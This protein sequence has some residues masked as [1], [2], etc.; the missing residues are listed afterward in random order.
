MQPR[1]REDT[2]TSIWVWLKP[3]FD[4]LRAALSIVEGP[5]TTDENLNRPT[6]IAMLADKERDSRP[7][8]SRS[9]TDKDRG[10]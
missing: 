5:D 10:P 7:S 4:K 9:L 2:K 3:L 6:S 8:R 1:R